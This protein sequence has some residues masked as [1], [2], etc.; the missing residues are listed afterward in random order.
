MTHGLQFSPE[1]H[2][3]TL[4]GVRLPHITGILEGAGLVDYSDIPEAML[5]NAKLRGSA[6][7]LCCA[8][9]DQGRLDPRTVHPAVEGHLFA[10]QMFLDD[11][12]AVVDPEW[13]ER[14]LHH[15][16][17]Q[18]AGTP[19][20]VLVLRGVC[21][22]VEIKT[23]LVLHPA[24][25]LQTAAQQLLIEANGG[26]VQARRAVLLRADGTYRLEPRSGPFRDPS[27]HRVFLAALTTQRWKALHLKEAA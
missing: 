13:I 12:G 16:T 19:D 10:W 26:T 11:T 5:E 18:Y 27:D 23:P 15:P 6:A 3:Y 2:T 1:A 22:V 17:W 4:D 7:H 21:T 9:Y 25:A 20:R 8:L 14:P 24:T